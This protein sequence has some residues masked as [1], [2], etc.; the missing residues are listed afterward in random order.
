M[1]SRRSAS[2]LVALAVLASACTS[3]TDEQATSPTTGA[4]LSTDATTCSVEPSLDSIT[5]SWQGAPPAAEVTVL[6]NGQSVYTA[7]GV[8][9]FVDVGLDAETTYEYMISIDQGATSADQDCGSALLINEVGQ[10][11][12]SVVL[13]TFAVITWSLSAGR[14]EIFRNSERVIP[15]R[16]S[17]SSPFIDTGAPSGLPLEYEVVAVDSS[18][19]GRASK[20]ASCGTV[21]VEALPPEQAVLQVAQADALAYR[22]PYAYVTIVPVCPECET[23]KLDIYYVYDGTTRVA[24]KSWRGS[25]ETELAD[26][27]WYIDPLVVPTMLL[28]AIANGENV[29]SSIDPATGLVVQWTVNGRGAILECLEMDTAPLELRTQDCGGSV[30]Q[31]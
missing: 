19:Q 6:R 7:Q 10:P 1:T 30:Y 4:R 16:G 31:D 15:E 23:E 24:T 26:E 29:V 25:F 2:L 22:G 27:I 9:A 5:V 21:T 11:E 3:G 18:G 12:C 20:T 13:D 14:A 8:E 28:E 17:L